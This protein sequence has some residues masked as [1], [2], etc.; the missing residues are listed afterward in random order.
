MLAVH[1]HLSFSHSHL[2]FYA[3]VDSIFLCLYFHFDIYNVSLVNIFDWLRRLRSLN[4]VKA[5]SWWCKSILSFHCVEWTWCC[6]STKYSWY[7]RVQHNLFVVLYEYIIH[8][9]A[10]IILWCNIVLLIWLPMCF[11]RWY[12]GSNQLDWDAMW[13]DWPNWAKES[14]KGGIDVTDLLLSFLLRS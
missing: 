1:A 4:G 8:G 3:S 2:C 12:I 14:C 5:F 7:E 9:T 10:P 11:F 6:F 13:F